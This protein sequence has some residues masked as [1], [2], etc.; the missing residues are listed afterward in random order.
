MA[1]DTEEEFIELVK[2]SEADKALWVKFESPTDYKLT[3][4]EFLVLF[5]ELDGFRIK[6]KTP[7]VHQV[8]LTSQ[9]NTA[10]NQTPRL[11]LLGWHKRLFNIIQNG[12]SM[13]SHLKKNDYISP[14]IVS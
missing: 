11:G 12:Q 6:L 9:M 2:K 14:I 8:I 7:P 5:K 10:V 1:I 13:S 3:R 4:E